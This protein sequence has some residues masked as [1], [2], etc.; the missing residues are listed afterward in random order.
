MLP[1]RGTYWSC[2]I[3][4]WSYNV[5]SRWGPNL[6]AVG[7]RKNCGKMGIFTTRLTLPNCPLIATTLIASRSR[8]DADH[9]DLVVTEELSNSVLKG[10]GSHECI[11]EESP[12]SK[13]CSFG[14]HRP[15]PQVKCYFPLSPLQDV[16][17]VHLGPSRKTSVFSLHHYH[18]PL[19]IRLINNTSSPADYYQ[20]S[21]TCFKCYFMLF[22]VCWSCIGWDY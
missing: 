5:P 15:G 8:I 9:G 2:Q 21:V 17:S 19:F 4:A 7:N 1:L 12:S 10:D 3:E 13:S 6:I 16:L 18:I 14:L 11:C 22:V 20:D